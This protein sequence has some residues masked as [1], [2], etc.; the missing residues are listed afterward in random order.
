MNRFTAVQLI[1]SALALPALFA[2]WIANDDGMALVFTPL[3]FAALGFYF[4]MLY[5]N[6]MIRRE[7]DPVLKNAQGALAEALEMALR[8]KEQEKK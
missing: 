2:M 8:L 4:G 6:K 7:L 1:G 3:W 5:E